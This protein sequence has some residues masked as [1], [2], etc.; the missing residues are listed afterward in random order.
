MRASVSIYTKLYMCEIRA[1][2]IG[3]LYGA[4]RTCIGSLL[5]N[6][7]QLPQ[8]P[9]SLADF[10]AYSLSLVLYFTIQEVPFWTHYRREFNINGYQG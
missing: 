9:A 5:T 10:W 3:Y 7:Y 1:Y 4:C 2:G 8:S 6:L